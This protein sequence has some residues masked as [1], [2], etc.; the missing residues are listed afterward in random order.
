MP[1]SNAFHGGRARA[2]AF[3]GGRVPGLMGGF[4]PMVLSNDTP[5]DH[6]GLD[7]DIFF[8]ACEDFGD[9]TRHKYPGVSWSCA[10]R[11]QGSIAWNV[12][13]IDINIICPACCSE[14]EVCTYGFEIHCASWAHMC[15][16]T[17]CHQHEELCV[18]TPSYW[19][20]CRGVSV[21]FGEVF[22]V[23]H[24]YYIYNMNFYF[25]IYNMK[26]YLQHE[27]LFLE[28]HMILWGGGTTGSE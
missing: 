15:S 1:T 6:E 16:S 28:R 3:H 20:I 21:F 22:L 24:I 23:K 14:R 10:W 12:L 26:Y 5:A 13:S 11:K 2:S 17:N 27:V 4:S 25:Y 19:F 7:N 8:D 18:R 9:D